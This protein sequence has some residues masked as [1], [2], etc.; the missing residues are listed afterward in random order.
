[1]NF[2][3]DAATLSLTLTLLN[4][5]GM[6]LGL[7]KIQRDKNERF[8]QIEL[9]TDTIWKIYVE[10]ALSDAKKGGILKRSS[11]LRLDRGV[12]EAFGDLGE[13]I[14]DW[15]QKNGLR[16]IT[17]NEVLLMIANRYSDAL[18]RGICAQLNIN[19]RTALVAALQL[20]K[21]SD[22]EVIHA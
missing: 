20:C 14:K 13:E 7:A 6:T 1:M 22:G 21:E 5:V 9:K 10:E 8:A 18:I 19:L 17:D 2:T 15:Y 4:I 16:R 3:L 12:A 11:P